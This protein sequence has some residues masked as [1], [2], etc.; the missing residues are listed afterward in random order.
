M[1]EYRKLDDFV[2]MRMN[3]NGALFRE[4]PRPS[5]FNSTS[6]TM[7]NDD[8]E[9]CLYFWKQLVANW[10]SRAEIIDYCVKVVDQNLEQKERTLNELVDT[11]NSA[12]SNNTR[13]F[14]PSRPVAE[15]WRGPSNEFYR[16]V[17]HPSHQPPSH[18]PPTSP[19][20]STSEGEK[21]TNGDNR[22]KYNAERRRK[23]EETD[24]RNSIWEER[25]KVCFILST[26][27]AV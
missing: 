13:L 26:V 14:D 25:V 10:K 1:K 11:Q 6:S 24:T 5:S 12:S 23:E 17:Q 21:Q 27:L 8:P 19:A 4:V 9:A 18:Q 15:Y 16:P 2:T 7:S 3:R 22:E 20:S